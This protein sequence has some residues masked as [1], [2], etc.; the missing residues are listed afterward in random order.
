MI[1]PIISLSLPFILILLIY[2]VS[3]CVLSYIRMCVLSIT[4]FL[5]NVSETDGS[6]ER[7]GKSTIV[8]TELK[9]FLFFFYT[10]YTMYIGFDNICMYMYIHDFDG[11][12]PATLLFALSCK[13]FSALAL[14]TWTDDRV[15]YFLL[16]VG[17]SPVLH[18]KLA[19]SYARTYACTDNVT[20][21]A[22]LHTQCGHVSAAHGFICTKRLMHKTLKAKVQSESSMCLASGSGF[23]SVQRHSPS[24]PYHDTRGRYDLT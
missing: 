11:S 6:S 18:I 9:V 17:R 2:V 14:L 4:A 8:H 21:E 7:R 20:H 24:A 22:R 1:Q 23:H 5:S 16:Q 13:K 10:N 15:S 19:C 3:L 12:I